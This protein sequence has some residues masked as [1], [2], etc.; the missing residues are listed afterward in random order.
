MKIVY[1]GHQDAV[2]VPEFGGGVIERGRPVD[3]PED[4]GRR[5]LEQADNWQVSG[6]KRTPPGG[7]VGDTASN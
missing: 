3:V 6:V 5:L 7:D 4:L 2:V 1:I